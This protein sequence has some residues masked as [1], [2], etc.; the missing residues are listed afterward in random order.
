[1]RRNIK[2]RCDPINSKHQEEG[3]GATPPERRI[4]A[5]ANSRL[6]VS[7][8]AEESAATAPVP[9]PEEQSMKPMPRALVMI[10]LAL[11]LIGVIAYARELGAREAREKIAQALGFDKSDD[12]HIKNISGRASDAI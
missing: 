7:S 3:G 9:V 2:P 11:S 1:M 10:A 5:I 12:V 4:I 6:L 8:L